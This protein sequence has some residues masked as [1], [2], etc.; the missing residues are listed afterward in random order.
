MKNE[1][2]GAMRQ[3]LLHEAEGVTFVA[4]RS[5]L[6]HELSEL[7]IEPQDSKTRWFLVQTDDPNENANLFFQVTFGIPKGVSLKVLEIGVQASE[8]K[9][10][11][12][13]EAVSADPITDEIEQS[14]MELGFK[15][16]CC[17][18]NDHVLQQT[19]EGLDTSNQ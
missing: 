10:L 4:G 7:G 14:L 3:L 11:A 1:S 12:L 9:P 18:D 17:F 8:S 19:L 5:P 13:M 15:P 16:F 2:D 6:F